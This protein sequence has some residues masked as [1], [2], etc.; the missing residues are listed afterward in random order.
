MSIPNTRLPDIPRVNPH[1]SR[2]TKPLLSTRSDLTFVDVTSWTSPLSHT[3]TLVQP[4][5]GLYPILAA[6]FRTAARSC[7]HLGICGAK[8]SWSRFS[9]FKVLWDQ[10][11]GCNLDFRRVEMTKSTQHR[12]LLP[13][14]D[15]RL[16]VTPIFFPPSYF[17]AAAQ[18]GFG[19][20]S[21]LTGWALPMH[22]P[23]CMPAH[24]TGPGPRRQKPDCSPLKPPRITC[25][26]LLSYLMITAN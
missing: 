10:P 21:W 13:N 14:S 3:H 22:I 26:S 2:G 12:L 16:P 11:L 15:A 18:T 7:M 5:P 19:A 23:S 20:M 6:V 9:T 8:A 17:G 25:V 24:Q 4:T 1:V